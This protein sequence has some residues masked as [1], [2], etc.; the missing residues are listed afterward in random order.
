MDKK[1]SHK[2]PVDINILAKSIVA[3]TTSEELLPAIKKEHLPMVQE[4][5]PAAV[6]L[7]RLGGLKGG[8]ARAEKLSAKRRKAIAQKAAKTRWDK[9]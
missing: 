2:Q 6:A 4:K 9:K 5:N 3:R 1:K 8:K 7:G